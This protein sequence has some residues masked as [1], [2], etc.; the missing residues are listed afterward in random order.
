MNALQVF[1]SLNIK[2][3][4]IASIAV[5]ATVFALSLL[6][7]QTLKPELD[8]LYSGLDS[9]VAGEVI[10]ELAAKNIAYEV[11]GSAIY[12]ESSKRDA[13]RLEL[14]KEGLPRQ[15]IQGYELF[16]NVN[17]FAMTSD[18][19]DT[20]YWRAKEGELARTILALPQVDLARVH[21]GAAKRT[22]F[23]GAQ[24]AGSAS[25][26]IRASGGI[27]AQ[28]AKAVQYLTA[29]SVAGLKPSDVV[30]VDAQNGI[31][32]GPGSDADLIAGR[33][34]NGLGEMERARELKKNLLSLLEARLGKGNVRVSVMLD[35]ERQSI[36][37]R[38][39][40]FDPEA[41]VVKSQTISEITD[42]SAGKTA[43][44]GIASNLPE[45]ETNGSTNQSSRGET[46]ET[47][48][49]EISELVRNST[50]L[51][52]AIKRISVAILVNDIRTTNEDGQTVFT[53]R[54][55]EE[56]QALEELALASAGIDEKRGDVLTIKSLAF[57][58]ADL[59]GALEKPGLMQQFLEQ[60]L[61]SMIRA[62]FLGL[63]VLLLGLFVIRPLFARPDNTEIH[64]LLGVDTD[65]NAASQALAMPDAQIARSDDPTEALINATNEDK[66]AAIKL[67][68]SWLET[69]SLANNEGGDGSEII[70]GNA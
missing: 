2:K 22:R 34:E 32:A 66:D 43:N 59:Q 17:S 68:S 42:T 28:T 21:L 27:S 51:P 11:R 44:V 12:A 56:L 70:G 18:M 47:I 45:G 24:E 31:V 33:M 69:D 61:W 41:R 30:V 37:L 55:A 63:I 3:Q 67:L 52:G 49:Y 25:V 40:T 15:S 48:Q 38:E 62:G 16:D 7:R 50:I 53:P 64:G 9:K 23:S 60:Y 20:A 10:A 6:V 65:T 8:L 57:E 54:S 19:F 39:R 13:L 14:A 29:L 46:T 5:I 26:T 1:L 58:Q 36:S 4:I 35:V